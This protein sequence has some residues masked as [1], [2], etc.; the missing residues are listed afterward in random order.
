[1]RPDQKS[2]AERT[3]EAPLAGAMGACL[4]A[5]V[6]LTLPTAIDA[7]AAARMAVAAWMAGHTGDTLLA[8]AQLVVTELVTTSVRHAVAPADAVITVRAE[9]RGDILRLEVADLGDSGSI[10]P[11]AP[12]LDRGGGFGLHVVE[13]LSRRWGVSR[14][15]G[16]RVWAELDFAATG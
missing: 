11:C 13:V 4:V 14:G 12:D 9:V 3:P 8:D 15:A 16:T 2:A 5:P 10:A 6:E 7:P 1:M